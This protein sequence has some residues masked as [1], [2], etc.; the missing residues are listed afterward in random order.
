MAAAIA[1][2]FMLVSIVLLDMLG[3]ILA[4]KLDAN[5]SAMGVVSFCL[6]GALVGAIAGATSAIVHAIDQQKTTN[7][8]K[9]P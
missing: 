6:V 3:M 7:E 8:R 9:Q 1:F 2:A 4:I 5:V